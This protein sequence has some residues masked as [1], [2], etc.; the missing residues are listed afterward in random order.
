[1]DTAAKKIAA[2]YRSRFTSID[3]PESPILLSRMQGQMFNGAWGKTPQGN[4]FTYVVS[5]V[6]LFSDSQT[7]GT[8]AVELPFKSGAHIIG[9]PNSHR[10]SINSDVMEKVTLEGD[11]PSYFTLYADLLQQ[12]QSR[13]VLDPSA[14]VFTVD[15]CQRFEWEILDDTLY[16][17]SG[18]VLPS[19]DIIDTFIDELGPAIE[20]ASDRRKNPYKMS[21]IGT[22]VRTMFCPICN[23][24]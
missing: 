24:K 19:F 10:F 2:A 20:V 4:Y 9:I 6:K 14:M 23:D 13:Y 18:A 1:M 3:L 11:Y 12:V 8:Y 15:F 5:G 21:Y 22:A 16:F 7:V 17:S